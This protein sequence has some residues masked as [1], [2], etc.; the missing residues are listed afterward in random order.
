M[1]PL[2]RHDRRET[3]APIREDRGAPAANLI[4]RSTPAAPPPIAPHRAPAPPSGLHID[5]LEVRIVGE[6]PQRAP[7]PSAP[8]VRAPSQ[9]GAWRPSARRFLRRP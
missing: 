9:L 5:Q 7:A 8:T 3:A 2:S 1:A 6:P 4:A